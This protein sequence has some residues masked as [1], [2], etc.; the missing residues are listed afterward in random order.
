LEALAKFHDV[1]DAWEKSGRKD[2]RPVREQAARALV[3]FR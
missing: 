3:V 1:F 2:W